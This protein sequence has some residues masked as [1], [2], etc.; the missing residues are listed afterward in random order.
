[1]NLQQPIKLTIQSK[2]FINIITN[3]RGW[4]DADVQI[5]LEWVED[6][7]ELL[8]GSTQ[9]WTTRALFADNQ[10]IN[11]KK[12][13]SKYHNMKASWQAAKKLQEQ[14][15]FGIREDD[16]SR[17]INGRICQLLA[18]Y[19]APAANPALLRGPQ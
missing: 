11:S 6:N 14:S 19:Q 15:G 17:S 12:I 16:C 3:M 18:I 1:M 9:L 8:R 5:L 2:L 10:S 13:K 7:R 4:E